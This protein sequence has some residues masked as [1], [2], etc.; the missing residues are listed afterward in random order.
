MP[1][2]HHQRLC[3]LKT[4][5]GQEIIEFWAPLSYRRGHDPASVRPG[6]PSL[7]GRI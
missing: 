5:I 7:L 3:L 6:F 4:P 1:D 2:G